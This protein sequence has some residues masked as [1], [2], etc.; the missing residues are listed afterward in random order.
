[1][2]GMPLSEVAAFY[3]KELSAQ[4]WKRLDEDSA[5]DTMRFRNDMME[6]SVVL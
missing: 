2:V 3:Q 6:L 1:V 4:G 5:Y